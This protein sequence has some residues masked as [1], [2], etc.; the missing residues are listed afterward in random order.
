MTD[1]HQAEID[2]NYE[3]F[4]TLLPELNDK[5]GKFALMRNGKI[6][7]FYDTLSDAYSTGQTIY[8]DGLFSVQR[9]TTQAVDLGFLSHAVHIR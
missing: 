2:S 6:I 7:N 3:V 8:E 9:V 4:Q 5:A 1:R